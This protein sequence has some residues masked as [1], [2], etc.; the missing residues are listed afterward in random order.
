MAKSNAVSK[1]RAVR[2]DIQQAEYFLALLGQERAEVAERVA[3]HRNELLLY[4]HAGDFAGVRRKRRVMRAMEREL[5][6]IDR[7]VAA[8]WCTVAPTDA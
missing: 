8:L 3:H 2:A 7:M 4:E 5:I 1:P 6:E